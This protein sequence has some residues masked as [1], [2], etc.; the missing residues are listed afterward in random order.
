MRLA[1]TAPQ[2]PLDAV[3]EIHAKYGMIKRCH[4][5]DANFGEGLAVR[6]GGRLGCLVQTPLKK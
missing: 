3:Y 2:A 1:V 5:C 4:G 6:S